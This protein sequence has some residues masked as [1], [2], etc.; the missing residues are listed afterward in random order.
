MNTVRFAIFLAVSMSFALQAATPKPEDGRIQ[1]VGKTPPT[2][3]PASAVEKEYEKLLNADDLAQA[4]VD[5][6]IRVHRDFASRGAGSDDAAL[7]RR[8]RERFDPVRKGYE[9][10]LKRHPDHTRA[11]VAYASFLGDVEGDQ[12]A[13]T[14]LE[15]ALRHD[16]NSPAIYNN[17]ANIHGHSGS[18]E[19][20]FDC[21]EKAIRLDPDEPVY[22]HNFGTTVYLFRR[23][24]S[25]H[26]GIDEQQVFNK[27]FQ[28]YSNAL[29][30]DPTNFP[31][32]SDVAQ[33]YYGAKPF[34]AKEALAAWT[35]VLNLAADPVEREGVY[36][37]LARVKM[38]DG[39]YDEERE[40][41]KAVTNSAYAELKR[42][43]TRSIELRE[44]ESRGTNTVSS[45][46]N[47]P[48]PTG[49]T[50]SKP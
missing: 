50:P 43:V 22:Y 20:A 15:I 30:L 19:K 2:V 6:W 26:Y 1:D 23:D 21:Y 7:N 34:R 8:I 16:T 35:N 33:V 37:H 45:A 5:E 17:L 27:A 18:L 24:A 41:L 29:R 48:P 40:H 25:E 4:E 31:L 11:R 36:V 38:L 10:F 39:R 28:L 32:A 3:D 44:N 12:A 46:T 13:R 9:D 49:S 47:S 42:R 14:Q